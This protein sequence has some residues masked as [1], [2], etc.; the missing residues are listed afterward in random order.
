MG[1]ILIVPYIQVVK[2]DMLPDHSHVSNP[3]CT[4][5]ARPSFLADSIYP[6]CPSLPGTSPSVVP[7]PAWIGVLSPQGQR[8]SPSAAGTPMPIMGAPVQCSLCPHL[9]Q[10]P[11]L[12]APWASCPASTSTDSCGQLYWMHFVHT[13]EVRAEGDSNSS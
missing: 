3:T 13:A 8:P 9:P 1:P 12:S 10:Q 11:A 5:A 6:A 2:I 4:K 7:D